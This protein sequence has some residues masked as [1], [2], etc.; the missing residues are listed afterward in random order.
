MS[1]FEIKKLISFEKTHFPATFG[2]IDKCWWRF[3]PGE[4]IRVRWPNG[5]VEINDT[6]YEYD[7]TMSASRYIV[8]SADPN[9]HYRPL[10]EQHVGKQKWDWDWCVGS[11]YATDPCMII[12]I[13]RKHSQWAA[14]FALLWA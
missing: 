8:D 3:V 13:R 2:L 12:K 4:I 14:Y 9:L 11:N 1:K 6:M 5:P 7:P 10:L